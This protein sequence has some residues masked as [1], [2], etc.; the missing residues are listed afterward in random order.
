MY[1][2][3]REE[4]LNQ[5]SLVSFFLLACGIGHFFFC[6]M[7]TSYLLLHELEPF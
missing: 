6:Q 7:R 2:K 5:F 3:G 4:S 1:V